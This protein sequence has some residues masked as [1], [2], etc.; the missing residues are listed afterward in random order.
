M[1]YVMLLR[2]GNLYGVA[3]QNATKTKC[4]RGHKYT[5]ANTRHQLNGAKRARRCKKCESI[6]KKWSYAK[7]CG[8]SL[9]RRTLEP[10]QIRPLFGL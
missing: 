3:K 2:I 7:S 10:F 4:P 1:D 9:H 5:V 6:Y 8:R